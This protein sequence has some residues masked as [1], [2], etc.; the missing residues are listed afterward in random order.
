MKNLFKSLLAASIALGGITISGATHADP[1]KG[2]QTNV[3]QIAF[4]GDRNRGGKR[5]NNNG[6]GQ[7]NYSQGRG[8]KNWNRGGRR[9]NWNNRR[10]RGRGHG[11]GNVVLGLGLGYL[12]F[13]SHRRHTQYVDRHYY[14]PRY[15][16]RY[17]EVERE[18]IYRDRPTYRETVGNAQINGFEGAE[19]LQIREY[20]TTLIIGGEEMEAYG[21]A[22]LQPDGSWIQGA[23]KTVPNYN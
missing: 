2:P 8:G 18:V 22:C 4:N 15:S 6:G 11:F 21:D 9:N 1:F 17:V 23:P 20:Q 10:G 5:Y 19:C 13:G 16:P 14:E 3:Q 12:M 7:K